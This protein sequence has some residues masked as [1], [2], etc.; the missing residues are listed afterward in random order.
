MGILGSQTVLA[1]DNAVAV[2]TKP[3]NVPGRTLETVAPQS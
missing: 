1:Q 3:Q 2:V